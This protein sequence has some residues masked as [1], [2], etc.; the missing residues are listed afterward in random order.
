M[1]RRASVVALAA[2]VSGSLGAGSAS[3]DCPQVRP[4]DP[5][6]Y[7][8]FA[9]GADPVESFATPEGHVR[10]WYTTAGAHAPHSSDSAAIAGKAVEE[11]I[12]AYAAMGFLPAIGDGDY[13]ACASNGGDGRADVYLVHFA[14][15][16]G[17]ATTERCSTIGGAERCS[18]F[19]LVESR[20][21]DLGYGT[22]EKGAQTVLPHEYFHLVQ[23]AYDAGMDRFWAE[24]TAQWAT[25]QLHPELT[26]LERFLSGYLGSTSRSIDAPPGGVVASFLYGT[27]I[28]PVFL[29]E[30]HTPAI[31]RKILEQQAVKGATALEATD[32]VLA[33]LTPAPTS[34]A[35]EFTTFAA[36]NAATGDRAGSGGYPL[37][38]SYPQVKT[39]ALS[40]EVGDPIKGITSGLSAT[41]Y[42]I[43]ATE[44]RLVSIDTDPSRNAAVAVPI[45]G[46][47]ALLEKTT[48]LPALIEGDAVI[49]IAGQRSLKTDAPYALRVEVPPP[50]DPDPDPDPHP[51]PDPDPTPDPPVDKPVAESSGC[52]TSPRRGA[53]ASLVGWGW[54]AAASLAWA[55][56]RRR[57]QGASDLQSER[58]APGAASP[59]GRE[60]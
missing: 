6:G 26:D 3:A 43:T 40:A 9:Y 45:A 53:A 56:R 12:A 4:T 14:G 38:A 55:A 34:L 28:W 24:G 2:L 33:S 57:R 58:R 22:F 1:R 27:A 51:D 41:Y 48:P 15:A 52:S 42:L 17:L 39:Q 11:A 60:E 16:D 29:S 8:G 30:R 31:V 32:A 5:G 36:W 21:D 35:A 10:V 54:A 25:K 13:P 47:V 18:G 23:N 46:G 37:A 49:V 50:P 44:A 7:E 19:I 59:A 20:L